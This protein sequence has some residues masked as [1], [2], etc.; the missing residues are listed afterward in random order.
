MKLIVCGAKYVQ[1]KRT[2]D[3]LDLETTAPL[4]LLPPYA[5]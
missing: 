5:V 3:E 4:A 2:Y 1:G